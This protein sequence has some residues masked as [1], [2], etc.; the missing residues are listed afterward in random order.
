MKTGFSLPCASCNS[1]VRL[2]AKR[3]LELTKQGRKPLCGECRQ[4]GNYLILEDD[5]D[6]EE[7]TA[8]SERA[9]N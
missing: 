4:M 9:S 2:T 3:L 8:D 7:D 1:V 5:C 6:E